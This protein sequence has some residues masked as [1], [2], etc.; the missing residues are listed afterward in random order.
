MDRTLTVI[1]VAL[2]AVV[3]GDSHAQGLDVLLERTVS[4]RDRGV[5]AII[6]YRP[7]VPTG[8]QEEVVND[9]GSVSILYWDGFS[10][11]FTAQ[12]IKGRVSEPDAGAFLRE[13]T[14]AVCPSVNRDRLKREWV[15]V[16][17]SFLHIFA[18]CPEADAA[19]D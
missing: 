9:D 15:R 6:T 16:D 17:G 10:G 7:E 5:R 4:D 13:A 19:R 18:Q 12:I 2:S 3:A 14:I 11:Q 1:S 8:G